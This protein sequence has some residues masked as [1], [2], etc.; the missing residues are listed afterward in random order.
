[1]NNRG[2]PVLSLLEVSF[3]PRLGLSPL[4]PLQHHLPTFGDDGE[5]DKSAEDDTA[6]YG[7][8]LPAGLV[9]QETDEGHQLE[10]VDKEGH[11]LDICLCGRR[12]RGPT[13]LCKCE[14]TKDPTGPAIEDTGTEMA[15]ERHAN[16]SMSP[17]ITAR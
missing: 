9:H 1:M 17:F 14:P 12:G 5:E 7:D 10:D 15:K 6:T 16:L 8:Q 13:C 11:H 4:D 2:S 3:L